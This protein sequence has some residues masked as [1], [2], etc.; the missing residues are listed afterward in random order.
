MTPPNDPLLAHEYGG[1]LYFLP[2]GNAPVSCKL[3]FATWGPDLVARLSIK[4]QDYSFTDELLLC[5]NGD[6]R[7]CSRKEIAPYDDGGDTDVQVV[8]LKDRFAHV[9]MEGKPYL[10]VIGDWLQ[11]TGQKKRPTVWGLEGLLHQGPLPSARVESRD[12]LILNALRRDWPQI[13]GK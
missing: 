1:T 11:W 2:S 6:D 8:L 4:H 12:M 9:T 5:P 10:R 3:E 13:K 7:F